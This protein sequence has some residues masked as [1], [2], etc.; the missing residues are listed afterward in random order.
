MAG[1]K[2]LRFQ[3]T[4]NATLDPNTKGKNYHACL[5]QLEGKGVLITGSSGA[6][7]TSLALG[8]LERLE[9]NGKPAFFVCDDQV[10]LNVQN[11]RLTGSAPETIAGKAEVFGFGIIDVTYVPSS[12]IDLVVQLQSDEEIERLPDPDHVQ[13]LE[14]KVPCISVPE[15]HEN[16]AARIVLAK[17]SALFD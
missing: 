5:V 9:R 14:I 10:I 4:M 3:K 6:G 16:Q 8:L 12:R 15:R 11:N 1:I 2:N 17:L 13:L 7:K